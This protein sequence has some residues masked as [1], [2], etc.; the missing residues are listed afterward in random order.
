MNNKELFRH[1]DGRSE[2]IFFSG[3]G[4]QFCQTDISDVAMLFRVWGQTFLVSKFTNTNA[5]MTRQIYFVSPPNG[6]SLKSQNHSSR[7]ADWPQI[8]SGPALVL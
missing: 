5:N 1:S 2:G 3:C 4:S 8:Y 6:Q 7:F